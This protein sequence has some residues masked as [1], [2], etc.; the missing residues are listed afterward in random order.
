M[1]WGRKKDTPHI[2]YLPMKEVS[3][4]PMREGRP[5]RRSLLALLRIVGSRRRLVILVVLL[6]ILFLVLVLFISRI[7]SGA[8]D[9][10]M[11]LDLRSVGPDVILAAQCGVGR[12]TVR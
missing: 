1:K 6:G 10:E 8:R 2:G 11:P 12:T 3:P 5:F 4:R 9:R 7:A